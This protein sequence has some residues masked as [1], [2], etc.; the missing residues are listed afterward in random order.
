[1]KHK[2]LFT[3]LALWLSVGAFAQ[4]DEIYTQ[5]FSN[6]LVINP[7]YAGSGEALCTKAL[8]RNQWV[9]FEGAPKTLS[10]SVHS[11]IFRGPSGIGF[12]VIND[13]IGIFQNMIFEGAYAYRI[14]FPQGKLSFG[15]SGRVKRVQIDWEDTNPLVTNDAGIPYAENSSFLPNIGAGIYFYNDNLYAGLS[16]PHLIENSYAGTTS[17]EALI[18]R[19]Y[20][21]TVGGIYEFTDDFKLKPGLV[22]KYTQNAPFQAD[23][24]LSAIFYDKFL[25][26][27]AYRTNDSFSAMVQVY[28]NNKFTIGYSHDF[29]FTKLAAHHKGTHEIFLSYCMPFGKFGVDNPRF[30]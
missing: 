11:P 3:L 12:S 20:V 21:G 7:A 26:G 13:K 9:G 23:I 22:L 16:A 8:Y 30:F 15:L 5:F 4:Q 17:E 24:N 2:I 18:R 19:Y 27:F 28:L 29:N 6:A 25:G 14:E 10:V 1:M